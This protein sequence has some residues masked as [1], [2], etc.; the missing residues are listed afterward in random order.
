MG[1]SKFYK[2]GLVFA[3]A[4]FTFVGCAKDR[5]VDDFK[6]EKARQDLASYQAVDGDYTGL[7]I[8]SQTKSP[9]GALQ[10]RLSA[11]LQSSSSP[12][13]SIGAGTPIIATELSFQDTQVMSL[14]GTN[15]YYDPD[16]GLFQAD[17]SITRASD[18]SGG[19]GSK[20]NGNVETVSL[21]AQIGGGQIV[22]TLQLA[23]YS[24]YGSTFTLSRNG[25]SLGKLASQ[26]PRNPSNANFLPLNTFS[27]HTDFLKDKV[28]KSVRIVTLQSRVNSQE[29]FLNLLNPV[30]TVQVSMNYDVSAQIFHPSGN[31]DLRTGRLSGQTTITRGTQV[32][33]L[34]FDCQTAGTQMNCNHFTTQDGRVAVTK[35]DLDTG[36]TVDPVDTTGTDAEQRH[37]FLGKAHMDFPDPINGTNASLLVVFPARSRLDDILNLFLPPAQLIL[38]ATFVTGLASVPFPQ[39]QWDRGSERLDGTSDRSGSSGPTTGFIP[40]IHC[41]GFKFLD[42]KKPFVCDYSSSRSPTIHLNL[43]Y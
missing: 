38:Q 12:D 11:R 35:A 31:W 34:S 7:M 13:G 40:E 24:S 29:D 23:G 25:G 19:S 30:K 8:S 32:A 36:P 4:G 2:F 41:T 16:S 43:H 18:T 3:A 27:G 28:S 5:T 9:V 20:A 6:R 14:A 33:V 17:I 37:L 21:T 10:L 1:N 39:V 26:L 22:G 42:T 15:A